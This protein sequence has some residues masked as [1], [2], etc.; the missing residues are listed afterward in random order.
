MTAAQ[1]NR[2]WKE[3]EATIVRRR[4][5]YI[6]GTWLRHLPVIEPPG[7]APDRTL[8]D[9]VGEVVTDI[10][11]TGKHIQSLS[12]PAGDVPTLM[13]HEGVYWLHKALHVLGAAEKH[14][15]TGMPTWSLSS[16]YQSAF[17]SARASMAFLGVAVT[18]LE[19]T[20]FVV[21]ISRDM[22]LMSAGEYGTLGAFD[23]EAHFHTFGVLFDHR[24][25]W[26]LFQRLL[27]VTTRAPWPAPLTS[28]VGQLNVAEITKQ[29]HHLHYQL[30][31]W[32]FDDL[33]NFQFGHGFD[34]TAPTGSGRDLFDPGAAKFSFVLAAALLRMALDPFIDICRYSNRLA[35][36]K[37][38]LVACLPEERH[39]ILFESLQEICASAETISL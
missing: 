35:Q 9:F 28:Y 8:S 11:A 17:F 6:R 30:Y 20:S 38:L 33:F 15:D 19:K 14:A 2:L 16:A 12:F 18:E 13:F 10:S 29:R 21:A 5:D 37:A 4:W 23:G 3:L 24:Q 25:V 34:Q 31:G 7:R 39:P 22:Q 26:L 27:R 36:E 32:V 1:F